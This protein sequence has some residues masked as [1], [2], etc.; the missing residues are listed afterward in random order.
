M[1][2]V[3][4]T[5]LFSNLHYFFNRRHQQPPS[6]GLSGL[7]LTRHGPKG[8]LISGT[9]TILDLVAVVGVV[10]LAPYSDSVRFR[11]SYKECPTPLLRQLMEAG[12]F[13]YIRMRR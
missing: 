9:D 4:P 7:V 3:E 2:E 13:V 12:R 6:S 11:M 10:A 8:G 1:V 5:R